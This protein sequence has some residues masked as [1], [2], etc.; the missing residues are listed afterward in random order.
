ME[1]LKAEMEEIG[2]NVGSS[3]RDHVEGFRWVEGDE[4]C[5]EVDEGDGHERELGELRLAAMER[6]RSVGSGRD[7]ELGA[8]DRRVFIDELIRDVE[9]D[10]RRLLQKVKERMERVGVKLPTVEVRYRNLSVQARYEVVGGKPLPT[11]WNTI[12]SGVN[13]L[14]RLCGMKSRQIKVDILKDASGIIKP[15]RMTLLLGPPGCGKTTFLL[16]LAGKLHKSLK[17][18][19][20]ITYNGFTFEEFYPEKTSAYI[21]QHDLHIPQMTVK[22]TLDFSARCQGI[23]VREDIVSEVRR[24]EKM[25]GIVPDSSIDTFMKEI[26]T[27]GWERTLQTD[28][29]MKILGL[30]SCSN[31]IVGDAMRRGISGGQRKRLTTG[32]MMVGPTRVLFMD[33]ISTGLDTSTT[34]QIVSCLQHLVHL[35][36][37]TAVISLL[38]PAPETFE[39]FDDIILM[40]E[41]KVIYH[42][43]R[44]QVIS[45]FEHCGFS[46]PERKG[47]ADYLQEVISKKDQAQYW[48]IKEKP[49]SYISAD[50]FLMQFKE[51]HTG[52]TLCEDLSMKCDKTQTQPSALSTRLFSLTKWELLKACL[53][54]EYLLM[55]R[56][57]FVY[58]FKIMQLAIVA[59]ITMTIFLRTE[60]AVDSKHSNYYMGAM[61]YT[62]IRLAT[63]GVAELALT[64]SRLPVFY[65]QRD[66]HFYPA[67]AYAIPTIVL[68]IPFSLLESFIWTALTYFVIGYSPEAERFFP[69]LVRLGFWA[70]PITY[71]EIAIAINEFDAPRW[72]KTLLGNVTIG[73]QALKSH[74][75]NFGSYLYW[76]SLGV[77]LGFAFVFNFGF[78]MALSYLNSPVKSST[79]V[80]QQQIS[81][82]HK[83][84]NATSKIKNDITRKVVLPFRPLTMTFQDVQYFI[85]TPQVMRE[86]GYTE[87]KLKLLNDITGAFRPGVLT[88]LMGISGAGKTTLMD[89]LCGRKTVGYIEGDIRI[90]GYPK[91]QET[92]AR[93]SGY[94]EQNDIHSPNITVKESLVYSAYLRLSPDIEQKTKLEF[95]ESVLETIELDNIKDALVGIPSVSGLTIEQRKRLTIAVELVSNPSIIFMD[96]PTSGLDA[97]AAAIVMRAVKNVVDTGRTVV[98]TIH[99]PSINIFESFDELFLMKR[100]GQIIYYGPLGH[101]SSKLIE[102]FERIPGVPK[103]KDNYNPATWMLEITATTMEKQLGLDYADLYMNSALYQE[104]KS[105]VKELSQPMIDSVELEFATQYPQNG[106][107]QYKACLWKQYLSYW[108]SPA[109]NLTRFVYMLIVSICF[110]AIFWQYGKKIKSEQ[111]VFNILGSMFLPMLF[112]GLNNSTA[113]LPIV[114]IE[115]NVLYREKCAGMY[116]TW[117]Y[118]FAQVTVEIPYILTQAFIFVSIVYPSVGYYWTAYKVLS[119]FYAIFCSLLFAT[120]L[121]MLLMAMS[122]NLEIAN[123]LASASYTLL[124]LFSGYLLPQPKIPKWWIWVYWI[125][126][127]S[128]TL[129]GLLTSQ[130]GNIKKDI[131]VY[132][133]P[134]PLNKF[135]EDYYNFHN[136][137]LGLVA[138]ALA[139]FPV[140]CALLFAY[141]TGK[142]NFQKR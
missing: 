22:E 86:Q 37:I 38:Q 75:L 130:Y 114:A 53:T 45:F 97:R 68:K 50:E 3:F 16:A 6:V 135:L 115:R 36:E 105:F 118:S 65:K 108:R 90:G 121:G 95:V 28:Y 8:G 137:Q 30:D 83:A 93:I 7:V 5:G 111:D 70:S 56:D 142:L 77:L 54:R 119:Y 43:P 64:V 51:F 29:I 103:I 48:S 42:G 57:A 78:T 46:C 87:K 1:F 113:V 25:Q 91:V 125:C 20:E 21:S 88:A 123:I 67:W 41:G 10:N 100:G 52:K 40:M 19:G 98:C 76:L 84:E 117:A 33:E 47:I 12:K 124:N 120:Y 73:K 81:S 79:I 66:F 49:Y 18:T 71:A 89:V 107:G 101:H 62:L 102:Y 72:Q 63:N 34:F 139:F 127:T 15:S 138:F 44:S 9:E 136:D 80:S 132:G 99:Q 112:F 39:L 129:N 60:M 23:G 35:S 131:L 32:E 92:F 82:M 13:G 122:P 96:E 69:S 2:R 126:P 4:G 141:F 140:V 55:K 58:V 61:F 27:K 26:S 128:W 74:G 85:D 134:K 106:W 94:C 17:V 31:T 24:R 109:Y 110:G 116:A 104:N 11:I 59:V 14:A 133:V